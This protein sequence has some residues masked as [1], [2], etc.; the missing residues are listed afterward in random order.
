MQVIRGSWSRT[1]RQHAKGLGRAIRYSRSNGVLVK[2]NNW[3]TQQVMVE[4]VICPFVDNVCWTCCQDLW[5]AVVARSSFTFRS[6]VGYGS[7]NVRSPCQRTCDA[8]VATPDLHKPQWKWKILGPM[9][10]LAPKCMC[11]VIQT[12]NSLR[13]FWIIYAALMQTSNWMGLHT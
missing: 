10:P 6:R 12:V 11:A 2:K 7:V 13:L 8:R 9:W 4:V 1:C 3:Q 5:Q